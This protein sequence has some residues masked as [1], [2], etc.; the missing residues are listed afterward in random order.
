MIPRTQILT[1]ALLVLSSVAV[2]AFVHPMLPSRVP[3][4][5]TLRGDADAFSSP[6]ILTILFPAAALAMAL[7]LLALPHLGRGGVG[8]GRFVGVYG[9]IAVLTIAMLVCVQA[10]FL[11]K[12]AGRAVPIERALPLIAGAFIVVTGNWM[13]KIRRNSWIGIRTPWTL[14]SDTVWERTHRLGGFLIVG[15]GLA[16]ILTSIYGPRAA[17]VVVLVGGAL[18]GCAWA[19]LYSWRISRPRTPPRAAS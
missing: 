4:H 11:F 18:T 7:V 19:I 5:W 13:G 16:T 12:A 3:T 1:I 14:A 15:L 9:R 10:V 2:A 6:W 8:I 17:G